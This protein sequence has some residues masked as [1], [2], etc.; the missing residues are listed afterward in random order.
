MSAPSLDCGGQATALR[1][2]WK[3]AALAIALHILPASA[4]LTRFDA[5]NPRDVAPRLRGP[6]LVLAGGGGDIA[7]AMQA[8]IDAAR[9][10]TGCATTLDVVV[11]RASGAD[12][13]N[14][15]FMKL[16]G[17]DSIATFVITD[18]ESAG[19]D[20][21]VAQVRD[22]EVVFFAGGD[23]CNYVRWI[24]GTKTAEAVKEVHRRGGVI[25]GTS[26]GLAIQSE[27]AYD[28][29]PSQSAKSAE[30]LRDPFHADVSLSRGFFDWAPMRG[31]I[32][33]THF[34]QRERL[35]RLV[36]FLARAEMPLGIGVSE[37]TAVVVDRKGRAKVY[38]Q[39]PVHLIRAN[40]KADVLERGKPLTFRGLSLW[41]IPA[42]GAFD[43]RR[44][45]REGG[46][47]LDVIEGEIR[48]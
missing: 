24:K 37:A 4:A 35:G 38:G 39:G 26:A 40:G 14:E 6:L 23:Q 29:C 47:R 41:E 11:L 3:A 9:G 45:P 18:R 1:H 44:R 43:L 10:C 32:A 34:L 17:V 22:A 48:R 46:R 2:T 28:A 8:A 21:V 27:V 36:V 20:D 25:G 7:E 13:Y 19:R 16:R 33:D 30:V 42:G 5:G 15:W 31:T 12:G